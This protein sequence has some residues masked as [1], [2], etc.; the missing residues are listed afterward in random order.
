MKKDA[1]GSSGIDEIMNIGGGVLDVDELG[2]GGRVVGEMNPLRPSLVFLRL[3]GGLALPCLTAEVVVVKAEL[4]RRG[5]LRKR[6]ATSM[7]LK[8]AMTGRTAALVQRRRLPLRAKPGIGGWRWRSLL[9]GQRSPPPGPGARLA[10][11][12]RQAGVSH[13]EGGRQR[14]PAPPAVTHHGLKE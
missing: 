10:S 3:T 7:R 6:A 9:V 12:Q 1:E 4:R 13:A 8:P 14:R 2:P 5:R 11:Q